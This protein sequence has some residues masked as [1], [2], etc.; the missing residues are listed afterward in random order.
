MTIATLKEKGVPNTEIA[1]MLA[2]CTLRRRGWAVNDA[3]NG[4][5]GEGDG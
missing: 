3:L 5:D 2:R 4:A 1:R